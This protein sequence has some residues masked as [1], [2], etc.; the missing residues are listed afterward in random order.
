MF[1]EIKNMVIICIGKITYNLWIYII[2]KFYVFYEI[3]KNNVDEYRKLLLSG[4]NEWNIV[5]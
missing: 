1:N 4:D 3:Y 2:L 5:I